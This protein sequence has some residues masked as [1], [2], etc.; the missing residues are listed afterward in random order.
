MPSRQ[1]DLELDDE[2]RKLCLTA[3]RD[4]SLNISNRNKQLWEDALRA[5]HVLA[6]LSL[7]LSMLPSLE[8]LFLGAG[9]IFHYPMLFQNA[10]PHEGPMMP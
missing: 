10:D 5:R 4:T 6:F 9:D 2:F 3:I 1:F 7:L 8:A